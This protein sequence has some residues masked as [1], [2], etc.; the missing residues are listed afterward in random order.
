[1]IIKIEV[2]Y[3]AVGDNFF[4][5]I[6]DEKLAQVK[7]KYKL[8]DDQKIKTYVETTPYHHHLNNQKMMFVNDDQTIA[9]IYL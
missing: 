6:S 1:M 9:L 3:N 7:L 2:I 4:Q 5:N 8:Q